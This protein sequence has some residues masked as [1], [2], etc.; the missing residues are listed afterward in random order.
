MPDS[1]ASCAGHAELGAQ[2]AHRLEHRRRPAGV[3]LRARVAAQL[4]AQQVGDEAVVADRA[5]VGRHARARRSA[6][7]RARAARRGSR[8]ARARRRRGGR[9]RSPAARSRRR[10]RRGSGA[11]RRAAARSRRRAA[12]G[13]T[14]RRRGAAGRAGWCPARRPRAGTRAS[15]PRG[16]A[17]PRT[18]AAGTAARRPPSPLLGGGEHVELPGVGRRPVRVVARDHVVG[19]DAPVR[20]DLREPA[21]D[22]R[23]RAARPRAARSRGRHRPV[24]VQLLQRDHRRRRRRGWPPPRASPPS[25][26]E[27]VVMHGMPRATAARRIS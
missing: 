26:P 25:R 12:R 24:A 16:G 27:T 23:E 4:G 18:R 3:D 2:R 19:A 22:G 11:G 6:P 1:S 10:R 20:G 13:S 9:S 21:A 8:A 15:R 14:G 7:P 5:V 17:G